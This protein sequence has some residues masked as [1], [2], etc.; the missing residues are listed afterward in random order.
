[1]VLEDYHEDSE[2]IYSRHS[3]LE[4]DASFN[5]LLHEESKEG[6]KRPLVRASQVDPQIIH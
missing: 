4:A 2:I 1:M 3:V 6:I 5:D